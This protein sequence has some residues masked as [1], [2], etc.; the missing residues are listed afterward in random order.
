MILFLTFWLGLSGISCAH[1]VYVSVTNMDIDA[2]KGTVSLSITIFTE[3]LET[4]LHNKYSIN[5]WIGTSGEHR[6]SRRMLGEYLNE[7]FSI[8]V[9]SGERVSLTTDSTTVVDD[10][11]RFYMKGSAKQPIRNIVIDNR[12][13]TDFFS[14]Q[15][16]LVIINSG[17]KETGHKLDRKNFKVELSL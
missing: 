14:K 9:N 13:L 6:D 3:D 11:M 7:R 4:V 16:N 8:S 15:T 10:A 1:P 12:L 2:P 17:K 5:G